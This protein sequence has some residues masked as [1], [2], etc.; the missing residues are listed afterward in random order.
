MARDRTEGW[1]YFAAQGD[2]FEGNGTWYLTSAEA[3]QFAHRHPEIFTSGP[4]FAGLASPVPLVPLAID[5]PDH[6]RFRKVL[7]PML[8]PRVINRMEDDLRNQVRELIAAFSGNGRC[9]IVA[10]LARLYPTQVFLT[11]FGMPLEDRDTFIGWVETL[12]EQSTSETSAAPPAAVMEA[13]MALFGYLQTFIKQKR[14]NPGDD[15]LSAVLAL[16]G[17]E[18]FSEPEVL[19]LCF[20]FTLAGLDTVTAT[21]GFVMQML[22]NHSDVRR[23]IV[24]DPTQIPAVIE[25]IL[26]MELSAPVTPRVTSQEVEIGGKVIPAGATVN[27]VLGTAN[28]DPRRFENP[29]VL[30]P[31]LADRGHLTFG[32]GIHRCLGSHLARREL[33]LV[34]EEF[35][36]VIPDYE[37]EPGFE[38]KIVWPS[39]TH[40]LSSL[41]IRFPPIR[42]TKVAP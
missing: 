23:R 30:D 1:A 41:P 40:H 5:P 42:S 27:L 24:D 2:V 11:L 39:G 19:G 16:D 22:A 31:E 3:V 10:D 8:A 32:G 15:M 7:D 38:P 4:A 37:I 13:A 21:I 36:R 25:E 28:R 12:V 29:D 9:D 18:A 26:R 33:R 6:L 34:V 35:L 20:L 17:D 14:A